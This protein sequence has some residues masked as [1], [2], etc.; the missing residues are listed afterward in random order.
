MENTVQIYQE[1]SHME[2]EGNFP[3]QVYVENAKISF[4]VEVLH[5]YNIFFWECGFS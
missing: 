1:T 3:P 4:D 2:F 5:N